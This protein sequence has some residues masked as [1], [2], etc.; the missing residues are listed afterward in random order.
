MF[1]KFPIMKIMPT[2]K[3]IVPKLSLLNLLYDPKDLYSDYNQ[4]AE[5]GHMTESY[6]QLINVTMNHPK[7]FV[8]KK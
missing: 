3:Y 5:N 8:L 4:M 1:I 2:T 7:R 6:H